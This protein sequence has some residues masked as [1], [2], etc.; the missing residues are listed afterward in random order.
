MYGNMGVGKSTLAKAFAESFD[1]ELV[2]FDP[3]VPPVTGKEYMYG[4]NNEF[5]L[6]DEDIDEVHLKMRITAKEF[7]EKGK[8]LVMESMFF[9]EQRKKAVL[10]AEN[11]GVRCFLIKVVC[12]EKENIKR[13]KDRFKN[14]RQSAGE[15]L[16]L[17]NKNLLNGDPYENFVIDT[18]RKGINQCVE[19]VAKRVGL[20]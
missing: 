8:S 5:L 10:L 19:D 6:S 9:K 16:F 2:Q 3:L 12:D 1:F 13:I 18:T 4:D 15:K 20:K 7:L 17:E 14:N 11:R